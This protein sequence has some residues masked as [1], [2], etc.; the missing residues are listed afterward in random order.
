MGLN[1]FTFT[2]GRE[3]RD[4]LQE[5]ADRDGLPSSAWLR[6]IIL[7]EYLHEFPERTKEVQTPAEQAQSQGHRLH[8]MP[9]IKKKK[10]E[11]PFPDDRQAAHKEP[12]DNGL[13]LNVRRKAV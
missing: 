1:R 4:K 13:V 3:A 11:N 7:R 9:R 5:L 12:Q 6:R 10:E 8:P 2:I